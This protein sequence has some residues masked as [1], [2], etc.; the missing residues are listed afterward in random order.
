MVNELYTLRNFLTYLLRRLVKPVSTV[1]AV[2]ETSVWRNPHRENSRTPWTILTR[3][4]A[5]ALQ[6][7][8]ACGPDLDLK[9]TSACHGYSLQQMME[10]KQDIDTVYF[11]ICVQLMRFI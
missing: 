7:D 2:S 4:L 1:L 8:D 3:T 11:N 9:Q 5:W 10:D 6:S